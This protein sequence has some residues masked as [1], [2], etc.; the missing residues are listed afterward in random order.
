MS[1]DP[2]SDPAPSEGDPEVVPAEPALLDATGPRYER[3]G[4]LG[5]GGMGR[6][7]AAWDRVLGREVALKEATTPAL[8]ARLARE[9]RITAQLEHPGIVSVY[10]AGI[11]PDGRPW[12]AMRMVRGRTLAACIADC[13]STQDRLDLVARLHDACQAVASAHAMGV[14]HRDLKPNNIM[15]GEFGETQ[16]VDWGLAGPVPEVAADWARIAP[17]SNRRAEGTSRY[18]SPEQA[19]GAPASFAADVWSLGVTLGELLGTADDLPAEL[20]TIH[21]HATRPDPAGRYPNA[22]ALAEDLGHWLEGRRVTAHEYSAR[23]LLL[24][25]YQAWRAPIGVAL[26]GLLALGVALA[27]GIRREAVERAAAERNLGAALTWQARTALADDRRPVAEILAASAL[28]LGPSPEARGVL[29][30]TAGPRPVRVDHLSLPEGCRR[31]VSSSPD[32]SMLAC[33]AGD[34]LELWETDPLRLRWT[35][36]ARVDVAPAWDEGLLVQDREA[37][38]RLD[39]SDGSPTQRWATQVPWTLFPGA[40]GVAPGSMIKLRADGSQVVA[41]ICIGSRASTAVLDGRVLVAC[42]ELLRIYDLEGNLLLERALGAPQDW[43]SISPVG[44]GALVGTFGGEVERVDLETG[45]INPLLHGFGSA[46]VQVLPVAGTPYLVALG[47]R[48]GARVGNAQSGAWVGTL[49]GRVGRLAPA[50]NPGEVRLLGEALE[51]WSLPADLRPVALDLGAGLSQVTVSLDGTQ[52]AYALGSGRVGLVRVADGVELDHWQWQEAVAKCVTFLED[53][54]VASAMSGGMRRLLPGGQVA[55]PGAGAAVHR[56]VGRLGSGFWGLPY[57]GPGLAYLGEEVR[58]LGATFFEGSSSPSADRAVL[59]AEDG[60]VWRFDGEQ[61]VEIDRRLDMVAAD[62]GDGGQ[63][64]V[65]AERHRLCVDAACVDLE[66]AIIDVAWRD[67]LVA[68]GTL[69]GDVLVIDGSSLATLA[70]LPGH[71]SRVSSVELG[72]GWLV[73]GSW[74]G[75]LRFWDLG[76]IREDPEVL[77]ADRVA[78]WGMDLD[79]A[80]RSH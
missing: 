13:R 73:S 29:A 79:Q 36:A 6:V 1:F 78:A 50:P 20:I 44:P 16:V 40:I 32:G 66:E 24:R 77:L 10:D 63:P 72:P 43:S 11:G 69:G 4:L 71:T 2:G 31:S 15:V 45:E 49:P 52:V 48:G 42:D 23:E 26:V 67:G 27:V 12:Y 80:L 59:L 17:G 51:T 30:A 5:V 21:R 37:V 75:T 25:L 33:L 74:D 9:A 38:M 54:L 35:R 62:I 53:G 18:M 76:V 7:Y 14:A 65:L 64:L 58:P 28:R 61:S 3:R 70:V 39:L 8:A 41:P 22:G 56:R 34:Q 68:V 19:E 47:A 46:V 60:G 57:V 55:E